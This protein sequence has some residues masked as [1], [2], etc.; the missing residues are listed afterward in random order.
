MKRAFYFTAGL[1][2]V[3]V[4]AINSNAPYLSIAQN[5]ETYVLRD[6][7][8]LYNRLCGPLRP[9]N[10]IAGADGYIYVPFPCAEDPSLPESPYV[11]VR[12]YT[13]DGYR[14]SEFLFDEAPQFL[15]GV[16]DR[17]GY[18]YLLGESTLA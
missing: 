13:P 4:F 3:A 9:D 8:P 6:T 16:V 2:L 1:L 12:K 14:V 17:D 11:R 15:D 7:W 18:L 5:S 10:A